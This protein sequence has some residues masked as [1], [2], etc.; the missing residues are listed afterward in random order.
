[1]LVINPDGCIDCG[2]CEPECPAGAIKDRDH[3][4]EVSSERVSVTAARS[5][6]RSDRTL[7]RKANIHVILRGPIKF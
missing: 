7:S 1:M 6:P 3:L 2:V 5:G 4:I